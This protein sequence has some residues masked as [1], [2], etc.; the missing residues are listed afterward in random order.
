MFRFTLRTLALAIFIASM[1]IPAFAHCF[2]GGR[3]FPA[4]LVG[5]DPC[6]ADEMSIPTVSISKNGDSPS[7]FETDF[8]AEYS[9]RITDTFGVSVAPTWIHLSPPGG[10]GFSGFQNLE[11]TF[12]SQ[13]L[14]NA[15]HEFVMSAGLVVE[16]GGSG[17]A[18]VGADPFSTV[19]PTLYVGK[20][21]GDLPDSAGW[22][23]AFG[24]SGQVG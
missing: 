9:K 17:S 20:G 3:F 10:P 1:P 8:A 4:N 15:A 7:A 12:K 5:D 6:V 23:R 11:T 19:T 13:F 22:I 2:V 18:E 21:L 16:W 14:T 24:V